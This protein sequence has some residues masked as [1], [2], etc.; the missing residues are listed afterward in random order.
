M[1]FYFCSQQTP[2]KTTIN[3]NELLWRVKVESNS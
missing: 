1:T 3:Q 2:N